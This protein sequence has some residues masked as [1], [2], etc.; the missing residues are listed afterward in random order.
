MK[1]DVPQL[2]P[3]M[4]TFEPAHGGR[5]CIHCGNARSAEIHS[6]ERAAEVAAVI[7]S[8]NPVM[9]DEERKFPTAKSPFLDGS[10][11]MTCDDL[12]TLH[13]FAVSIGLRRA[14]FQPHPLHPHYDLT[15]GRRELALKRGAVFVPAKEQARER[16]R[17]RALRKYGC[18]VVCGQTLTADNP[19]L[20][21]GCFHAAEVA[22]DL[23]AEAPEPDEK[24]TVVAI[25]VPGLDHGD[26]K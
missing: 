14:W 23:S 26:V 2:G 4:C 15:P 25:N 5:Q 7:A 12:D 20:C 16:L 8:R 6:P 13:A 11:H 17:L 21:P 22:G 18:C 24:M 3:F 19:E 1:R 9:V 10:C